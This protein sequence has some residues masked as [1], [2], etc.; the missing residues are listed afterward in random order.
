MKIKDILDKSRK[1]ITIGPDE[2]VSSAVKTMV[3]NKISCLPVVGGSGTVMGVISER[4]IVR[5][6]KNNPGGLDNRT[7]ADAMTR[8]IIIGL[9]GDDLDYIMNIMA[10]NNIRHVPIM[11][12]QELT[13]ILSMRDVVK[14]VM[15]QVE[16]E[17]RYLKDYISGKYEGYQ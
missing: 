9:E 13:G 5:E 11:S 15:H 14:G 1:I 12:G 17:N 2:K 10:R 16:A 4:D 7:V 6:V 8:D 3:D